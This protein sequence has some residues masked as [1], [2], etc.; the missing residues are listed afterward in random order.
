[1]CGLEN[2]VTTSGPVFRQHRKLMHQ[3]LGT[4]A[5]TE[6][7]SGTED[8]GIKRFLLQVLDDPEG[9]MDHIKTQAS[10]II[11]KIVYGYSIEPRQA[12]PLVTIVERTMII[13]SKTV[14]PF[15][16]AVDMIPLLRHLPS[17]LPGVSFHKRARQWK[18]VA[19]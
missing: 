11:L 13:F 7:F 10:A 18:P 17:W 8:A 4:R 2:L 16:W 12:D 14:L 6:R 1:M 3:Q 15:A 19:E 9:L 5:L